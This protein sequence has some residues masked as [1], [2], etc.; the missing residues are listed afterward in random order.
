MGNCDLPEESPITY[1]PDISCRVRTQTPRA[2]GH[3]RLSTKRVGDRTMLDR[4][5]QSGSFKC[6]FPNTYGPSLDAVL[7]NTAGGIT[8]GDR[9]DF[10]GHAAADTVLTLTT[11]A[12]ERAYK[13][14]PA[15]TGTVRNRLQ[16]GSQARVNWLPQETILFNGSAISR[17]MTVEMQPDASL[18]MVEPLV[19][20]RPAMGEQ[21]TEIQFNDR[22]DI[23]RA[24]QPLLLDAMA[25][26]GDAQAHLA[27][28]FVAN[29][30]GAMALIVLVA[31]N[32]ETHMSAL[33]K[34]LPATGGA[35][36]IADDILVIRLLSDDSFTLRQ[37]LLPVLQLLNGAALPRCWMM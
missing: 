15:E 33:Q 25:L 7:L 31:A 23:R 36:L 30:A 16:I 29:G 21:L 11:Q 37:T 18:L 26:T 12:C 27:K 9:F 4:C 20:G 17:Q 5:H 3:L 22:I 1:Q 2:E 14:Q 28:P 19:F 24:G 34:I 6:L 13:A 32:A 8:G 35:S 10:S